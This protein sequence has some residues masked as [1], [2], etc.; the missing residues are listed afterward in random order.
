MKKYINLL[1]KEY[2]QADLQ[3]RVKKGMCWVLILVFAYY[4]FIWGSSFKIKKEIKELT[5]SIDEGEAIQSRIDF[6]REDLQN[7]EA[8]LGNLDESIFPFYEFNRFLLINKPNDLNLIS[9]DTLDRLEFKIDDSKDNLDD[10]E[11]SNEDVDE[12]SGEDVEESDEDTGE[13]TG[14]ETGEDSVDNEDV[15]FEDSMRI[16][17][18]NKGDGITRVVIR[19]SSKNV[20]SI[21][22]YIYKISFLDYVKDAKITAIEKLETPKGVENV[23]EI[24]LSII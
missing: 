9:V 7:K 16:D 22:N 14:E 10:N 24:T 13:E 1:P 19:G 20:Q 8:F 12:A 15:Q 21:A 3:H 18:N 4:G 5:L 2:R 6:K 17:F 11:E 23:F